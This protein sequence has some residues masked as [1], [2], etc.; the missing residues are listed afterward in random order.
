MAFPERPDSDAH[1]PLRHGAMPL[2][3]LEGVVV[4][5]VLGSQTTR[6]Q[7]ADRSGQPTCDTKLTFRPSAGP[8]LQ[9]TASRRAAIRKTG[10]DDGRPPHLHEP[11]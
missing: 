9:M 2:R 8:H 7:G 10:R 3:G 11:F 4:L 5:S 6:H 1:L